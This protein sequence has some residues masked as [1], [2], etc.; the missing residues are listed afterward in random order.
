M[1]VVDL[2]HEFELGVWKAVFTHLIRVL[3]AVP[4]STLVPTFNQ[5][6]R[7]VPTFGVDTIRRVT[8]D[9][10]DRK[11]LA[12]RDYEDY[13]Q[14]IIPVIEGLLPEPFNS[15]VLTMLFRLAEWHALA[16]LRLHTEDTVAR[17]DKSTT[18]IG[19]EL[20]AFRDTTAKEYKTKELPG[21]VTA[22]ARQK[23]NKAK[24]APA[25]ISTAPPPPPAPPR[26][27]FLNLDTYKFH[28]LGDYPF[29]IPLFGTTDSFSTQIVCIPILTITHR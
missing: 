4:G 1:L 8:S 20:R 18:I 10:S 22:R 9:A 14:T 7:M 2:L 21:E 26:G 5:R 12:A 15:A 24:N 17:F 3:F 23:Q 6:F 27:K 16:K 19:H 29:T 28:A 25:G 11:K 13:L